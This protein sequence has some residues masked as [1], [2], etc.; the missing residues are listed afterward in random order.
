MVL[1]GARYEPHN[2][3]VLAYLHS[4]ARRPVAKVARYSNLA[5]NVPAE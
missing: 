1:N 5:S 4:E 2:Y 3:A